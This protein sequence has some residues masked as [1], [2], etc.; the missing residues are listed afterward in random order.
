MFILDQDL[1][2]VNLWRECGIVEQAT[3]WRLRGSK[4][5][6]WEEVKEGYMLENKHPVIY[7]LDNANTL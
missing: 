4:K 5:G 3:S 7:V 6:T 2:G 1:R